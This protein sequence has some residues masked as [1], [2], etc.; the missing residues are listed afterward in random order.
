MFPPFVVPSLQFAVVSWRFLVR[1]ARI[2][3]DLATANC[4][5]LLPAKQSRRGPNSTG[6]L[7]EMAARRKSEKRR[8]R[9]HAYDKIVAGGTLG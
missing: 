5:G 2:R 9:T 8:P 1:P 6:I 4:Q 7:N 3:Y